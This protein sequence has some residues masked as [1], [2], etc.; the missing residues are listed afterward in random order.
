MMKTTRREFLATAA[1]LTGTLALGSVGLSR[2][3][4]ATETG[5]LRLITFRTTSATGWNCNVRGFR[6]G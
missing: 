4:G 6:K 2:E 5:P 3:A 1:G